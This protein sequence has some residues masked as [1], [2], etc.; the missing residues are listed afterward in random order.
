MKFA[1]TWRKRLFSIA[2]SV[3]V[4]VSMLAI[5][6]PIKTDAADKVLTLSTARNLA[7]RNSSA[8]ELAQ[9]KVD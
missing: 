7:I 1:R 9:M 5:Y 2:L 6:P 8:Y 3:A 4:L